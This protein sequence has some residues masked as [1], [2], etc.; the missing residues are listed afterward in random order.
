MNL[1]TRTLKPALEAV[2]HAT[3]SDGARPVLTATHWSMINDRLVLT[4][5]D[6]FMLTQRLVVASEPTEQ[7]A[8]ALL[9]SEAMVA[10]VA[11]CDESQA[12]LVTVVDGV[13]WFDTVD[14][15][16]MVKPLRESPSDYR[17][18]FDKYGA[19]EA[20]QVTVN[21]M[22]LVAALEQAGNHVTLRLANDDQPLLISSPNHRSMIMPMSSTP[23][24]FDYLEPTQ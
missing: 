23:T 24:P 21:R 12:M 9:P 4:A 2:L 3:S 17:K 16:M 13:W 5:A 6:G 1:L 11:L 10:L 7:P 8:A 19:V 22:L 15:K 20:H 18:V 14:T